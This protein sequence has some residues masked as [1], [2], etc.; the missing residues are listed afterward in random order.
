MN[1]MTRKRICSCSIVQDL[2][3]VFIKNLNFFSTEERKTWT[4]W[5][6]WV[7]ATLFLKVNYSF[8]S[9]LV[10]SNL[11]WRCCEEWSAGDG[12]WLG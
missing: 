9:E 1:K 2:F 3:N 10:C 12:A 5:M 6:T 11:F 4:S 8:K 7:S